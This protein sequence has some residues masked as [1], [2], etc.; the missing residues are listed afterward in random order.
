LDAFAQKLHL[1]HFDFFQWSG[2]AE[3]MIPGKER[4]FFSLFYRTGRRGT[5]SDENREIYLRAYSRPEALAATIAWFRDSWPEGRRELT[6]A[7]E[8]RLEVPVLAVGG[9]YAG[10]LAP[11]ESMRQL[12]DRVH[13]V[14]IE[15]IGHQ[16]PE[17]APEELTDILLKHFQLSP[18]QP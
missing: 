5:I 7:S 15:G 18:G 17:E 14:F 8:N 6:A 16:I 1:W 4:E 13:G 12:A 9:E 3:K 2:A 10:G 11:L